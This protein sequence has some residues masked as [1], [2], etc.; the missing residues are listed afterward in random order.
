MSH[1]KSVIRLKVENSPQMKS[2]EQISESMSDPGSAVK[3]KFHTITED[4]RPPVLTQ[5]EVNNSYLFNDK[6]AFGRD[7]IVENTITIPTPAFEAQQDTQQSYQNQHNKIVN[8]F[9]TDII[10]NQKQAK[11][12]KII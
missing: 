10:N 7:N 9:I 5:R 4:T 6:E 12:I 11:N 8:P 1:K 2:I 3:P